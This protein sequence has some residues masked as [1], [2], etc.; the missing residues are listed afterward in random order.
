[1]IRIFR[2]SADNNSVFAS[3]ALANSLWPLSRVLVLCTASA[4]VRLPLPAVSRQGG[5]QHEISH[6]PDGNEV[7]AGGNMFSAL[8]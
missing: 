7:N 6:F 3:I 4:I 5:T 8:A 1:M 2:S